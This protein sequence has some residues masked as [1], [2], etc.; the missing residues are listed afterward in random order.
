MDCRRS[1]APVEGR[2][3]VL[4]GGGKKGELFLV[5]YTHVLQLKQLI[6]SGA[7]LYGCLLYCKSIN[8]TKAGARVG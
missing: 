1:L 6:E 4:E 3:L 7:F 8:Q 5:F 2:G